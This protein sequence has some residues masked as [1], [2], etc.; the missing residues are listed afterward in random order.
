MAKKKVVS[1]V[2]KSKVETLKSEF[3]QDVKDLSTSEL[4]YR[5]K[6][7]VQEGRR[8][9]DEFNKLSDAVRTNKAADRVL[10]AQH[11]VLAALL[12]GRR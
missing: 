7:N 11:E 4:L 2:V 10:A 6:A 8:L 3:Y 5:L 9:L 12:E 1:F